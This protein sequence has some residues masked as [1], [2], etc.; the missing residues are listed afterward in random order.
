MMLVKTTG[1]IFVVSLDFELNW[2]VRDKIKLSKYKNNL[3]GVGNALEG[4]LE[5][6]EKYN[7]HATWATVGA[8]FASDSKDLKRFYPSKQPGY[9]DNNL[10]PYHYINSVGSINDQRHFAPGLIDLI[11]GYKGQEIATHTFSH[12]YCLE[13]GQKQEEFESDIKAAIAIAKNRNIE[14]KSIVFPRNQCNKDYLPLLFENGIYCYRGNAKGWLYQAANS[15]KYSYVKRALRLVDAYLNLS[16][17]NCY[18]LNEI[19][20]T[21]PYNIPASRFLRPSDEKLEFLEWLRMRRIKQ[22]LHHAA[23][24]NQIFHLWWHPHNFGT[25]TDKNLLFLEEI[26]KFYIQLREAYGMQ[27]FNMGEVYGLLNS[28]D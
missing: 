2:G 9:L 4:M 3:D 17:S 12:Y 27:S 23:K 19:K 20:N 11:I 10:N 1:G 6:F 22:G 8:I 14:L 16:G 18:T 15:Q 5:L 7:I 13:A 26:L 21:K 28:S 24:N 25:N